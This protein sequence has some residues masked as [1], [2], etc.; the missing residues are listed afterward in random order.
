MHG[1]GYVQDV[2]IAG[3]DHEYVGALVFPNV[4]LCRGLCPDV[5]AD[6]PVRRVL[7]D[8][9][10]LETFRRMLTELAD[11][12]TGSSTFVTR[13]LLLDVPPSIDARE[14]TDKGSLNQKAVLQNRGQWVHE[15]YATPPSARVI[16]V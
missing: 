6:A 3:Q 4:Q 1:G 16:A 7:D 15:L 14:L 12:S 11:R 13:A 2:V 9:R 5:A 10:V 8:P